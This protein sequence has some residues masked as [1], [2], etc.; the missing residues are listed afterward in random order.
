MHHVFSPLLIVHPYL[1]AVA[2]FPYLIIF[3]SFTFLLP[4]PASFTFPS[5]YHLFGFIPFPIPHKI[6]VMFQYHLV[7]HDFI[8]PQ[9]PAFA[10]AWPVSVFIF[11]LIAFKPLLYCSQ[12]NVRYGLLGIRKVVDVGHILHNLMSGGNQ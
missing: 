11:T 2:L 12:S 8:F 1:P 6:W 9:P 10:I 3:V 4:N 5:L 7:F